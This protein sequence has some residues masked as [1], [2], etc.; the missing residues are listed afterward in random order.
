MPNAPKKLKNIENTAS[1]RPPVIAIMGHIDHGKSTLLDKIRKTNVTEKEMG[2][3]TQHLGAY[4]ITHKTSDNTESR[5]TFLDTP[6]HEAFSG[7][8]TRGA[9]VADI[10]IL[11]VSGEEGVKP[12][13]LEAFQSIKKAGIPFVV[14]INKVDSP[15]AD[16]ERTKQSLAEHEIYV[17]G[18]GGDTP[19]ISVSGKTGEGIP[20]LLDLV[21]LVADLADLKS[22]KDKPAEGVVVESHM[23]PKEGLSA[24]LIIKNGTLKIGQVAVS[25]NTYAVVRNLK[26]FD[27]TRIEMATFSS[28]VKVTGWQKLPTVGES[29]FSVESKKQA[30]EHIESKKTKEIR[31]DIKTA[32]AS[33]AVILH[34]IIKADTAGSLEAILNEIGKIKGDAVQ[35]RIMHSDLGPISLNDIKKTEGLENSILIGF[36]VKVDTQAKNYAERIGIEIHIFEIIYRL[37]E[38]LQEEIKSKTPKE[39][40]EEARGKAKIIKVFSKSKDKQIVGGRV[41]TGSIYS[42]EE[43]KIFRRDAEIGKGKIREL[44]QQKNKATEV[45][46]GSEFGAQ[47][48]CQIEIAPGDKIEGYKIIEK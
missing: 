12:Q 26:Y 35:S 16:I 24:T 37:T 45:K 36:N 22:E 43:V 20:E 6:G 27:N 19:W 3:I 14:A 44:Q 23:D 48:Q 28:P 47:I 13:T 42:G 7:I 41:E 9:T 29:F 21:L 25:G 40:I 17:E 8:R 38:W 4:E 5:M 15:K 10:A 33:G 18:Y 32:E 2:G 30:E 34:L 11:V 46:N 39:N 1:K 31:K